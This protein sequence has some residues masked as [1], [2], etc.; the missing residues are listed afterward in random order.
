[1]SMSM[2]WS[3]NVRKSSPTGPVSKSLMPGAY[4][5]ATVLPGTLS[6]VMLSNN[7]SWASPVR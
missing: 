2:P 3:R 6:A 1:M 5:V 7:R 4:S